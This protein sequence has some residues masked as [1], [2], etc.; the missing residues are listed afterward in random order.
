MVLE[1][2]DA[3]VSFQ[4][5]GRCLF[6]II[7]Q[8]VNPVVSYHL[9]PTSGNKTHT[10]QSATWQL[11]FCVLQRIVHDAELLHTV[12]V[13]HLIWSLKRFTNVRAR[14]FPSRGHKQKN[15]IAA[16]WQVSHLN[17]GP[18]R[19]HIDPEGETFTR[20]PAIAFSPSHVLTAE[21]LIGCLPARSWGAILTCNYMTAWDSDR[22]VEREERRLT[23]E[24][25]SLCALSWKEKLEIWKRLHSPKINQQMIIFTFFS[26]S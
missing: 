25:S 8:R 20:R 4:W 6:W 17:R 3:C 24:T 5:W 1:N 16:E 11:L 19:I 12:S 23:R 13:W 22:C 15:T 14:V 18:E 2:S 7:C 21:T 10:S 26:K 9:F